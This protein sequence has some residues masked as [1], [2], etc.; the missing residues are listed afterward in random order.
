MMQWQIPRCSRTCWQRNNWPLPLPLL[1]WLKGW[2]SMHERWPCKK[3]QRHLRGHIVLQ[4]RPKKKYPKSKVVEERDTNPRTVNIIDTGKTGQGQGLLEQTWCRS[5][6]RAKENPSPGCKL[7]KVI[8]ELQKESLL[9]CT[10]N[11]MK[12]KTVLY[13]HQD[14]QKKT[15]MEINTVACDDCAWMHLPWPDLKL[16]TSCLIGVACMLQAT[17]T[18]SSMILQTRCASQLV[19]HSG[20]R[21]T[22]LPYLMTNSASCRPISS[23]FLSTHITCM[24]GLHPV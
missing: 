16:S 19:G 9:E 5:K 23:S 8:G 15:M 18:S 20:L 12:V 3:V 11:F 10:V 14:Q 2:N 13:W 17:W 6:K 4:L 21:D 22:K 7:W 1:K 24:W